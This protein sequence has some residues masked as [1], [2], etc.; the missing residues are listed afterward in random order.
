MKMMY[1]LACVGTGVRYYPEPAG[2]TLRRRDLR[3]DFEN[4]RD[5]AAVLFIY[6][7][8]GPNMP[9]RYNEYVASGL[10]IYIAERQYLIVLVYL[11]RGDLPFCYLAE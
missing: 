2:Q 4:M 6:I 9:L 10:R 8:R 3:Y 5:D 11:L 7:R 1:A